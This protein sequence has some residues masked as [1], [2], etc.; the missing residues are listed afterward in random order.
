MFRKLRIAILLYILAFAAVG[1]YLAAARST[2]W[3][4]TLWIDV[5]PINADGSERTQAYID[6]LD[7]ADFASI[8]NYF[9]REARRYGVLLETPF[10]L[11][12][13]GQVEEPVPVLPSTA[14]LL[15]TAI[16]SLKMRW[17]GVK[18]KRAS[19][20]PSPDIQLFA[21]YHDDSDV[22]VLDRSTALERGLIA[23]A[24]VFAGRASAGSNQVVMA[25]EL[26]HTLGATDKYAIG[27]NLPLYPHGFADPT[28]EPRY[29]QH[30]AELMAGRIPLDVQTA[31]TPRDLGQ[32]VV[33][34]ITATEIGW[35]PVK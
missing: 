17:Y 6:G 8:E 9:A 7:E 24:K 23:V 15:D 12:L 10:R 11:K 33:G 19:D 35:L 2:D 4:N 34:P 1:N 22:Q 20:R 26:L 3:N 27:T 18:V 21:L 16:W 14:G 29:P 30:K 5:Y 13:A 32:T 28:A 31:A 25:H